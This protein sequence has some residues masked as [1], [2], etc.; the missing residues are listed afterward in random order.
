MFDIGIPKLILILV[1]A[2]MI[3]GPKKLPELARSIGKGLAA[4]KKS[5]EELKGNFALG[6]ELESVQKK[7]NDLVDPSQYIKTP[8]LPLNSENNPEK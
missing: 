3:L 1:V 5:V 8:E 4:L 2:L 6:D 7:I